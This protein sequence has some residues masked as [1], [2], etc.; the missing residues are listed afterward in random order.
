M[1]GMFSIKSKLLRCQ[2]RR[3]CLYFSLIPIKKAQNHWLEPRF[4][5]RIFNVRPRVISVTVSNYG[6]NMIE[7]SAYY[8]KI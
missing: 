4:F 2:A 6:I 5:D 8:R 7:C 1:I 3:T